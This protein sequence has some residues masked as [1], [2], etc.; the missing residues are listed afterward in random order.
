[1]ALVPV[2][3]TWLDALRSDDDYPV[4]DVVDSFKPVVIQDVGWL[5]EETDEYITLAMSYFEKDDT[6]KMLV[7][8]PAGMVE[9]I[10][11]L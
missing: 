5:V 11:E 8:I 1:M 4:R 3:V 9:K 2:R 6:V 10:E 7:S